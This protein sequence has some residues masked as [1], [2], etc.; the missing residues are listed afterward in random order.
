LAGASDSPSQQHPDVLSPQE[1]K[2]AEKDQQQKLIRMSQTN[3]P[4]ELD[5][6]A[7]LHSL[8]D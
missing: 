8:G 4:M 2:A 7:A 5:E 1:R 6:L 3:K